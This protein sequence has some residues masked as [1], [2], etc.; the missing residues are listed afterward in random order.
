MTLVKFN[1]PLSSIFDKN[2]DDFVN[3][4]FGKRLDN[5]LLGAVNVKENTE[6]YEIQVSVP[7]LT[8]DDIDVEI[9]DN[10]ITI[11]SSVHE[12]IEDSNDGYTRREFSRTSFS[13][14]FTL[15]ENTTDNDL[16]GNVKDGI[17]L[18]NIKKKQQDK[19]KKLKLN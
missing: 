4:F 10:I 8:K 1:K 19:P 13:R 9:K 18:I 16:T 7:G 11:S 6:S 14:S 17:L 3:D 2:I 12:N 15:P 5:T